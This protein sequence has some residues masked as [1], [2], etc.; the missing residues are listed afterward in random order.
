MF[1]KTGTND[2]KVDQID[3][4]P[5]TAIKNPEDSPGLPP[6]FEMDGKLPLLSVPPNK[7]TN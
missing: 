6:L 5:T 4:S 7:M 1:G 2:Q 3:Y